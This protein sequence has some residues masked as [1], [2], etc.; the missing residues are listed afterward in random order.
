MCLSDGYDSGG[1]ALSLGKLGIQPA[2]YTVQAR[3]DVGILVER[4]FH[5]K[6]QGT[7]ASLLG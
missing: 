1:I 4:F 3:E 7:C 2:M 6:Q 5:L